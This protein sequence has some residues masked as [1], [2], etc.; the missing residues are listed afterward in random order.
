MQTNL[1]LPTS[2]AACPER[3]RQATRLRS[4]I[5][6]PSTLARHLLLPFL[7][8][9]LAPYRSPT[10]GSDTNCRILEEFVGNGYNDQ[11]RNVEETPIFG[12]IAPELP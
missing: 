10:P 1:D 3:P 2:C 7:D 11:E 9:N 5:G 12:A 6:Q 4:A 8:K